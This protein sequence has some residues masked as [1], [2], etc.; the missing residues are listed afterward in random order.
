MISVRLPRGTRLAAALLLSCLTSSVCLA[1]MRDV[2]CTE[3][4]GKF[5]AEFT[6]GIKVQVGAARNGKLATRACAGTLSWD[7]QELAV[8]SEASQ[9]DVD[10]FGV[11]L[12]MSVPV[13]TFQ[14]K[15]FA[16]DCCVAYQIYTLE[17]PPRLLRTISGGDFFS[18]SDTDLDGR[19]EI[20]TDDA[21]AVNSF[22]KLALSELDFAPTL[23][24]RFEHDRLLDVSSE[25]PAYFD[26]QIAKIR[27]GLRAQ[28]L[29]DFKKSDGRLTSPP[30]LPAEQSHRLRIIEV[31]VLE[32]VWSYLYSGREQQAWSALGEMW[33]AGDVGRIRTEILN[34]RTRGIRAQT[35]GESTES[36][37]SRKRH[38]Q[39]FDAVSRSQSERRLEVFPPH[40]IL[41]RRPPVLTGQSQDQTA[42]L[43]LD[44]VIDSAGKVRS[45]EPAGKVKWADPELINATSGWKFIPAYKDGRPV[46]CRL[47]LDVSLK[48]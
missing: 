5:E 22:E 32:I 18:A 44:L 47:R 29:Q 21:A 14:V 30:S 23:V 38:A 27:E 31:R 24:L 2:L 39:I 15:K 20:W 8:A 42:E 7:K 43:L 45:A 4:D 34:A 35:D 19:I 3:G 48:Q 6:P 9:L 41:L 17:K 12:G 36:S 16:S 11:D 40:M 10:G 33:P 26:S 28:D 46:A 1:Q 25:F 13:V 37:K